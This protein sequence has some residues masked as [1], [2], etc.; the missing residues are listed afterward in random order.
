MSRPSSKSSVLGSQSPRL[1]HCSGPG[2]GDWGE[3][4]DCRTGEGWLE[5]S[6]GGDDQGPSGEDVGL[7]WVRTVALG[8][9]GRW[10]EEAGSGT[11]LSR[12]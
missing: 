5:K 3:R 7:H 1:Q 10:G 12:V 11:C 2:L 9:R 8:L 4:D 6:V